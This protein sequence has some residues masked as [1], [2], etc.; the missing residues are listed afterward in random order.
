MLIGHYLHKR[1]K[2]DLELGSVHMGLTYCAQG[3][4]L[5]CTWG[6]LHVH[7]A[8]GLIPVLQNQELQPSPIETKPKQ[9]L[10]KICSQRGQPIKRT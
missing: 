6:L 4:W 9:K 8:L 10:S 1:W 7:L 5:V 3:A 2:L